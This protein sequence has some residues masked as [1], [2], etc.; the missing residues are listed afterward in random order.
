MNLD[1]FSYEEDGRRYVDPQVGYNE[2]SAFINNFRDTQKEETD[3]IFSDTQRLG[4]NVPSVKGGLSGAGSY[5]KARYQTPQTNATIANLKAAASAQALQEVMN[6]EL[7]KAKKRYNDARRM[8]EQSERDKDKTKTPSD[9]PETENP[10]KIITDTG[11]NDEDNKVNE[12]TN[13]GPGKADVDEKGTYYM[14]LNG[15]KIY[16]ATPNATEQMQKPSA[17]G[18]R[19]YESGKI[20]T[21]TNGKKYLYLD[22]DQYKNTWFIVK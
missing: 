3:K 20:Y 11:E 5:F 15:N 4:T 18:N 19:E 8:A 1:D 14:D 9:E 13:T 2:S 21:G 7:A 6:N 10:L 17:L 12:N 16:L 22:N